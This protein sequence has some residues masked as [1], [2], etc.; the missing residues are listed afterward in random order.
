[1]RERDGEKWRK[2]GATG[3]EGKRLKE[4]GERCGV[5]R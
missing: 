1:M 4:K 5:W 3:E 2:V